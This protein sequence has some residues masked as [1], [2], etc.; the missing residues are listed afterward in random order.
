MII[1]CTGYSAIG[2]GATIIY[3]ISSSPLRQIDHELSQY[4]ECERV[5]HNNTILTGA[6]CDRSG[7]ER[8]TNPTIQV[9]AWSLIALY[10]VITLIYFIY[11]KR[12]RKTRP[13]VNVNSNSSSRP[14]ASS[15]V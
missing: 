11:K 10:P 14:T 15:S 9:I 3:G 12:S 13:I 1:F 2:L 6:N 8:L 5:P 7:F 4:F